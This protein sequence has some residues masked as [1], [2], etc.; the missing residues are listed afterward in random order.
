MS[1]GV[2]PVTGV[3]LLVFVTVTLAAVVGSSVAATPQE[4][5]PMAKFSVSADAADDRITVVHRG[6]DA[7]TPAEIRL[8]VEIDGERLAHQPPVPFFA[9]RGF[10][11]GPTGPLNSASDGQWRAGE[12][13][14]F[15]LAATND[16]DLEAGATVS[17]TVATDRSVVGVAETRAA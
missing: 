11:P 1:R 5:P 13:A 3:V 14:T 6:G 9:T 17:V 10:E 7:I 12:R 15:R 2:A 4:P 8:V 16:P